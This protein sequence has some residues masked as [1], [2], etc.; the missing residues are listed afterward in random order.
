MEATQFESLRLAYWGT[1]ALFI[2][3]LLIG[4]WNRRGNPTDEQDELQ[5]KVGAL[6]TAF[7]CGLAFLCGLTYV[8]VMDRAGATDDQLPVFTTAQVVGSAL[9]QLQ[10]AVLLV[11]YLQLVRG[12]APGAFL[13]LRARSFGAVLA[14]AGGGL[15]VTVL[16]MYGM[17]MA[18][19]HGVLGT[20]PPE[21]S[22]QVIVQ[23]F[24]QSKDGGLRLA[25]I[26]SAAIVA[27]LTEELTY[28]GLIYGFAQRLTGHWPAAILSSALFSLVHVDAVASLPLFVLAVGLATA[29]H[30]SRCLW[31]PILMHMLFN[32]WNLAAM[33]LD[34]A[35]AP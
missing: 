9:V 5:A 33:L 7:I 20:A 31:V 2:G 24:Q 17:M 23:V 22:D 32:S 10:F 15:F 26:L 16:L 35:P 8:F 4:L 34:I 19:W 18:W 6:D 21:D 3:S 29:Y 14:W 28:R 27:P 12:F 25:I 11:L 1:F 13:G 30:R